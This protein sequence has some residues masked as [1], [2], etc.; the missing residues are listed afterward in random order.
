MN[1]FGLAIG[2]VAL[3]AGVVAGGAAAA[4]GSAKATTSA[5]S[6]AA[7][8]VTAADVSPP[9]GATEVVNISAQVTNDPDFTSGGAA[10]TAGRSWAEGNYTETMRVWRE[11]DGSF[12]IAVLEN[13]QST[14]TAGSLS[15]ERSL[16][17]PTGGTVSRIGGYVT[18]LPN[19][20]TLNPAMP[21]SGSLGTIDID[22]IGTY[23]PQQT[24]YDWLNLYFSGKDALGHPAFQASAEGSSTGAIWD[25]SAYIG[26]WEYKLISASPKDPY[27]VWYKTSADDWG[28]KASDGDIYTGTVLTLVPRLVHSHGRVSGVT[29]KV[30]GG[31][32]G[33]TVRLGVQ[34]L[35][36]IGTHWKVSGPYRLTPVTRRFSLPVGTAVRVRAISGTTASKV[37]TIS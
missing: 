8:V 6:P 23:D 16:P 18:T 19:T 14:I 13:G 20:F 35:K 34:W 12:Y 26:G 10:Q 37:L 31:A 22:Q 36:L 24:N 3:T 11:Q 32:T 1:R 15:P 28:L 21:T 9:S 2:S 4:A 25:S 5:T 29:F 27:T 33:S 17:Q 30:E 7:G